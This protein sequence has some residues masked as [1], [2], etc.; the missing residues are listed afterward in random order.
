MWLCAQYAYYHIVEN[1]RLT[2][3]TVSQTSLDSHLSRGEV[4]VSVLDS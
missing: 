4:I 2:Q 3:I 1:Q